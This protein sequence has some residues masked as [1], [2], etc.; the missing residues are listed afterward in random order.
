MVYRR[1]NGKSERYERSHHGAPRFAVR[2]AL[3]SLFAVCEPHGCISKQLDSTDTYKQRYPQRPQQQD[4][5]SFMI[6]T[7]RTHIPLICSQR[8]APPKAAE[9][10]SQ[11]SVPL[12]AGVPLSRQLVAPP[13]P[14]QA[15]GRG[16]KGKSTDPQQLVRYVVPAT[17]T[18][19]SS[20]CFPSHLVTS[21]LSGTNGKPMR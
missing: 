1:S 20:F 18:D 9:T 14:S 4:L 3:E 17:S 2:L 19:Q 21:S 10:K 7:A 6:N 11:N 5:L 13:C 16:Y 12:P 8:C 15:N